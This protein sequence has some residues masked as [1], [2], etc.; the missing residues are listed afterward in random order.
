MVGS[1]FATFTSF[2]FAEAQAPAAK[3]SGHTSIIG[4]GVSQTQSQNGRGGTDPSLA[5]STSDFRVT[6]AGKSVTNFGYKYVINFKT[7]PDQNPMLNRNYVEFDNNDFGSIQIGV[8]KGVED[9]MPVGPYGLI[10]GA[11]GMNGFISNGQVFNISEGVIQGTN[12]VGGTDVATK[13]NWFSPTVEIAKDAGTL[14]I[15]FSYT[16]NTSHRGKGGKDN[17]VIGKGHYGNENAIYLDDDSSPVPFGLKNFIYGITY[18]NT[19][20]KDYTVKLNAIGVKEHSRLSYDKPARKTYAMNRTNSYQ[21][22]AMLSVKQ[23]D[24]AASWL[25]NKKSRLLTEELANASATAN[26]L[27]LTANGIKSYQGNSGTSWNVGTRYTFGAYQAAVLYGKTNRK[28]D[29]TQSAT[30]DVITTTIDFKALE[31]L[32]FFGEVDFLRTKTNKTQVDAAQTYYNNPSTK[33]S[34]SAVANNTG[35]VFLAG[36]KVS[37]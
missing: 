32:K 30:L 2:A 15:A 36:T 1:A 26:N 20:N 5:I 22:S 19:F 3:F 17:G 31:G 14:Q 9:S 23:W 29:A 13:I 12:I 25:D 33:T 6:V 11:S 34:N 8:V 24:F 35:T 7:I 16:P 27:Y 28:T 18:T 37:F 21:V 10:G 4:Y